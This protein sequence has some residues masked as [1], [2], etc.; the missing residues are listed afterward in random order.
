M[1]ETVNL[2]LEPVLEACSLGESIEPV[3]FTTGTVIF[4]EGDRGDCA[5]IV[6]SGEVRVER[7]RGGEAH[8]LARLGPGELLGE[9]APIDNLRR[10]ATA[11][12]LRDTELTPIPRGQIKE[13]LHS[14]DPMLRLLV[15]LLL[16]R[17]RRQQGGDLP[18]PDS[19]SSELER[20]LDNVRRE[21]L[22]RVR[23][24]KAL[25]DAL[26]RR[27]LL[28]HFQPI[29]DLRTWRTSGFEAL[30]R[31][32]RPSEGLVP[33]G[34]FIPTVE[35]TD[36]VHPV[37]LW[38]LRHA[39]ET[40]MAFDMGTRPAG[41]APRFM[42][43]NVSPRQIS[44]MGD[45]ERL[46]GAIRDTGVDVTR[47]KLE[48]TERLLIENPDVAVRG[49]GRLKDA[50]LTIAID[51]FGTGYSSLS[52]LHR[53]PLDTLKIDRSFVHGVAESKERR[54]VVEAIVRLAGS[55]G[56]DVVAEGVERAEDLNALRALD[57][58]MAQGY[59]F[60]RPMPIDSLRSWALPTVDC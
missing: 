52:Y 57:V 50:G 49:L 19:L 31:W 5:Y 54:P 27:E 15:R 4:R 13:L 40:A 60:G 7:R 17:L 34:R 35:E 9:M 8:E 10:S 44:T 37:G 23:M 45:V 20:T 24:R 46:L 42:S 21:A 55:L 25:M 47:V 30:M 43:I 36:L 2:D 28:L 22:G 59:L 16:D 38:C 39:C 3:T 58:S 32:Q 26:G 6:E 48:V 29:I 56:M 18:A 12:A 51:D 53:F 14:A 41:D 1:L 11:V 33:P